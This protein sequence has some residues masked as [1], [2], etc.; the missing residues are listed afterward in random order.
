MV[1]RTVR[2]LEL[3]PDSK[4]ALVPGNIVG[5]QLEHIVE[6]LER[7][8]AVSTLGLVEPGTLLGKLGLEHIVEGLER[9]LGLELELGVERRLVVLERKLGRVELK[10]IAELVEHIVVEL[11][12]GQLISF[13]V[14]EELAV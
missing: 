12:L 3:A 13:A 14:V 10:H 6:G 8:L 9:K 4:L 2:R 5:R 11:E 7:K 1:V